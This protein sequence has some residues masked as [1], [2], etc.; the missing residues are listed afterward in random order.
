MNSDDSAELEAL[1]NRLV[2]AEAPCEADVARLAELLRDNAAARRRYRHFMALH[3]ALTWDYAA[4]AREAS[5][6]S[7]QPRFGRGLWIA[8]AGV[9][10]L[11]ALGWLARRASPTAGNLATVESV[12]GSVSWN[13]AAVGRTQ[14]VA[15]S[16]SL[17]AGRLTTDG[18]N[19]AVQ[20]RLADGTRL[21]L[22]GESELSLAADSATG[23]VIDLRRGNLDA[24]AESRSG[25]APASIRTNAAVISLPATGG[26]INLS[27][28]ADRTNIA[29]ES[30][31]AHLLRLADGTTLD[32]KPNHSAIAT[33]DVRD[34]LQAVADNEGSP[35]SWRRVFDRP[36]PPS[37]KGEWQPRDASGG[38]RV[39]AVPYVAGRRSDGSPI[40]HHGI[41]ARAANGTSVLASLTSTTVLQVRWRTTQSASL[42]VFVHLKTEAGGFGGNFEFIARA[43][44]SP[45][46]ADGWRTTTVRLADLE[47][48]AGKFVTPPTGAQVGFVLLSTRE[49][50]ADLEIAEITLDS[51]EA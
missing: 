48:R 8:A 5:A 19:A 49:T 39:R 35:R 3:S 44:R 11:L 26:S 20:L 13:D 37:S 32:L 10:I 31:R 23:A 21:S 12:S 2:D 47:P 51:T 17:G 7:V 46:A 42:Q 15:P 41:S 6:A 1:L 40:I 45:A 27:A 25:P 24:I 50:A 4:A 34:R 29:V 36:P 38:P 14:T 43:E 33:L 16:A 18:E 9:A 22:N 30:G 28:E